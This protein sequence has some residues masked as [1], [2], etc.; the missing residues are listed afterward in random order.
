VL[1]YSGGITTATTVYGQPDMSSTATGTSATTLSDPYSIALDGAENVYV[2][3]SSNNRVLFYPV[4]STTATRVYGQGGNMGTSGSGC[5][6]NSLSY[7]TGVTVTSSGVY[8]TDQSNNRVLYY[9][10]ISTTATAVWGQPD[11]ATCNSDSTSATALSSPYAV[12]VDASGALFVSDGGNNR[13]LHFPHGS[14]TADV[15]YGQSSFTDNT[16]NP[17]GVSASSL[18][19]PQGIR[20]VGS[21]LYVADAGN[22]RVLVFD[23][24]GAG[25][26]GDPHFYGI[27]GQQYEVHGQSGMIYKSAHFPAHESELTLQAHRC[28]C[29][30]P[31]APAACC[32]CIWSVGV[33]GTTGD[34][35]EC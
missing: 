6:A 17:A 25:V 20:L 29:R 4:G 11:L 30:T 35:C 33:Q 2:A 21:T 13:V 9:A 8:I 14:S 26:A 18:N 32:T 10:G 22:E 3:D 19:F 5:D 34:C 23:S 15:V 24:A 12:A 31:P 16:A 1:Y 27:A 7:P 28:F